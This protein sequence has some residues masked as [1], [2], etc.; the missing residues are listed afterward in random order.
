MRVVWPIAVLS[1]FLPLLYLFLFHPP[2]PLLAGFLVVDDPPGPVDVL[3]TPAGDSE[4]DLYAAELYRKGLAPKIIMSGCGRE[5]ARMAKRAVHAGVEEKDIVIEPAAE[6]TYE[7]ALFSRQI[8]LREDFKSAI[9]VT[10]PYHMRRSKLVFGRVF[11][12]TGVKLIY[13]PT[14]GSGFNADGQCKSET[15]RRIVKR[16][17]IKLIYYWLRYW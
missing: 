9:V 3:I 1:G 15:D 7:N 5:A 12:G 6:S 14:T 11:R 16:E 4:R 10:S 2:W 17:Y 8:V 13:C